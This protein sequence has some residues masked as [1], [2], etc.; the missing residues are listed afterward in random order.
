M[1]VYKINNIDKFGE[2]ND[3][4]RDKQKVVCTKENCMKYN[5]NNHNWENV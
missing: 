5:F 2:S 1:L 3:K 4:S